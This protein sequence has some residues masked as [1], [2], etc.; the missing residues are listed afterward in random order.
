MIL[1]KQVYCVDGNEYRLYSD[2]CDNFPKHKYINNHLKSQ[3]HI[4]N[5]YKGRRLKN[6]NTSNWI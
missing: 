5:S 4:D 2:I 1:M 6:T 3:T